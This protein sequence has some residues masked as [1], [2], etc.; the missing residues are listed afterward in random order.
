[1]KKFYRYLR[2]DLN[3][4]LHMGVRIKFQLLVYRLGFYSEYSQ[5]KGIAKLII[6]FIYRC[7]KIVCRMLG[8]NEFPMK[9]VY[10]GEGLRIPHGFGSISI[11]Q[12]AKIGKRA[13][14][15]HNVTIGV[16]E[17]EAYKFGDISIGDDVYIGCG[18]TILGKCK[19]GNNVT[20]GANSLIVGKDVPDNSR[21]FAPLACIKVK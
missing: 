17:N 10:I 2:S 18:A 5:K 12:F 16:I 6:L 15:F 9:E 7:L 20:I 14:I 13:T 4:E 11:S 3:R 8:A 21:V 19:I 1:M